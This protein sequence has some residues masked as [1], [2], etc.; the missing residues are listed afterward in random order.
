MIWKYLDPLGLGT[1]DK[2]LKPLSLGWTKWLAAL[3]EAMAA[4]LHELVLSADLQGLK[5]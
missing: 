3:S 1:W 4:V 2:A 5:D